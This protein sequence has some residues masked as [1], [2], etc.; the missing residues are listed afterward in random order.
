MSEALIGDCKKTGIIDLIY[1]LQILIG[2]EEYASRRIV[3]YYNFGSVRFYIIKDF[4]GEATIELCDWDGAKNRA[5]DR[6]HIISSLQ[7]IKG[8]IDGT[9]KSR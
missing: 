8:I 7:Q 4:T 9:Q 3:F 6:I 2:R 1:H 5:S